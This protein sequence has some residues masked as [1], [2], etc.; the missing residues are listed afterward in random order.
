[1][2][3][4][5]ELKVNKHTSFIRSQHDKDHSHTTISNVLLRDKS[6]SA[7]AR[8]ALIQILSYPDS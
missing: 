6:I 2:Q 1:M 4:K 7:Q 8:E 3:N 5:K